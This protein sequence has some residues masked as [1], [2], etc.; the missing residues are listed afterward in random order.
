ML[1]R[2]GRIVT[3]ALL[4]LSLTVNAGCG[5]KAVGRSNLGT[6]IGDRQ[7]N[8]SLEGAGFISSQDTAAIITFRG[9]KLV[10]DQASVQ[11]DGKQL[12]TFPHDAKKVEVDYTAGKVTVVVDGANVVST[13]L[14]K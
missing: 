1:A 13:E 11:L 9:G 4:G 2:F 14:R 10:V 5:S 6:T 12:G 8:A 7:V 3:L